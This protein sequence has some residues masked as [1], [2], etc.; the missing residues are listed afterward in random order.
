MAG[1]RSNGAIGAQLAV[2]GKTVAAH[3]S[4]VFTKF[5]LTEVAGDNG[6]VLAVLTYLGLG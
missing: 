2:E 1:G 3:I 5:G 4:R 6:R